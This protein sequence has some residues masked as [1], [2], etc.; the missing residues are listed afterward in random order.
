MRKKRKSS[1]EATVQSYMK[2]DY[3]YIFQSFY[4]AIFKP[5]SNAWPPNLVTVL[6]I[7]DNIDPSWKKEDNIIHLILMKKNGS[8]A[9]YLLNKVCNSI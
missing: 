5:T 4:T 3:I 1:L 8:A 6:G 7:E 9:F 2:N